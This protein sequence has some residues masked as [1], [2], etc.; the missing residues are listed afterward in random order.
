MRTIAESRRAVLPLDEGEEL[1]FPSDQTHLRPVKKLGGP[2]GYNLLVKDVMTATPLTTTP[3]ETLLDAALKMHRGKVRGLPVV[4]AHGLLV[5]VITETDV[6]RVLSQEAGASPLGL[7]LGSGGPLEPDRLP[8]L[9][10]QSESILRRTKV[11][12]VMT[13]DPVTI[14]PQATVEEAT[15]R[16]AERRVT[17]LPVVEKGRVIGIFTREDVVRSVLVPPRPRVTALLAP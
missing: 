3:R 2:V 9:L 6:L 5:G 1:S 15:R 8:G 13:P 4:R 11:A 7:L 12:A 14:D 17:R 16:L 10:R